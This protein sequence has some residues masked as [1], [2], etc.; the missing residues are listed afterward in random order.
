MSHVSAIFEVIYLASCLFA[1][2]FLIINFISSAL[3]SSV[4]FSFSHVLINSCRL[5][6]IE[7]YCFAGSCQD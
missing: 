3:V 2:S 6:E 5:S 1:V 4:S 7:A